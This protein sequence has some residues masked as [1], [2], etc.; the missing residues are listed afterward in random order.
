M[1]GPVVTADPFVAVFYAAGAHPSLRA[2]LVA[3]SDVVA[4]QPG[5]WALSDETVAELCGDL[6][7]RLRSRP[8]PDD[9]GSLIVD[10]LGEARRMLYELGTT[11]EA[12]LPMP[13]R[14]HVDVLEGRLAAWISEHGP[15][16]QALT[17]A[18]PADDPQ[19][20]PT[21]PAEPVGRRP[22]FPLVDGAVDYDPARWH[23]VLAARD[24][25]PAQVR[26]ELNRRLDADAR[27][28]IARF[29]ELRGR[30]DLVELML[31]VISDL[32][33]A[34]HPIAEASR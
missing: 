33:Q 13:M 23:E 11:H 12:V 27:T 30:R 3:A 26:A 9:L 15:T 10:R 22:T 6:V 25:S 34:A 7:D 2:G 5:P 28:P 18:P 19:T 24:L 29:A 21:E 17:P 16:L 8:A 31:H 4:G 1:T 32:Y 14:H 20:D